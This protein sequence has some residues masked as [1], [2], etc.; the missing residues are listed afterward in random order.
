MDTF[1][2]KHEFNYIKKCLSDLDSAFKNCLDANVIIADKAYIQN[3]IWSKF[4][5]LSPEQIELLDISKIT[6]SISIES[7]SKGLE[8]YVYGA[9]NITNAQINRI[10]KKEKKIKL[11][12]ATA[13]DSKLV[14][15]G[16]I[17]ESI[18]KLFI[19]YNLDGKLVG[20]AC[21]LLNTTTNSSHICSLCNHVGPEKE[22]AFVS[23]VCKTPSYN[24][25]AYRSI[26]FHICLDSAKCNERIT[27]VEKLESL[28]K[29]VNN[30]K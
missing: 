2:K 14:Y 3:K 4:D 1:I 6:S 24:S 18:R 8:Q 9:S 22:V 25:D 29:N 27:S 10:F 17:D 15:L 11:P 7:F 16:W 28:L 19:V 20:M 5:Y 23:P 12:R 30:I 13:Q 26:G 21:R